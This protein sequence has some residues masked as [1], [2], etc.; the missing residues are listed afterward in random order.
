MTLHNDLSDLSDPAI[1][2][3]V[4]Q[5]LDLVAERLSSPGVSVRRSGHVLNALLPEKLLLTVSSEGDQ[6]WSV[7]VQSL[8]MF[9]ELGASGRPFCV[10]G[11]LEV[12]CDAGCGDPQVLA[13]TLVDLFDAATLL[14]R[15]T[16]GPDRR[17]LDTWLRRCGAVSSS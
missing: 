12:D 3:L 16:A 1:A 15:L 6:P 4:P 9:E 17:L 7:R 2:S 8:V 5:W 14:C 10:V 11:S 13:D